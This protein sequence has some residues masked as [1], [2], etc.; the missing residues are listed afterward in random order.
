LGSPS[1]PSLLSFPLLR[2][3]D[4]HSTNVLR[5]S[6]SA[7]AAREASAAT[8]DGDEVDADVD[9]PPGGRLVRVPIDELQQGQS[10]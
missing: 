8:S 5:L 9:V 7:V 2:G 3:A 6:L 1:P 10:K 4:D